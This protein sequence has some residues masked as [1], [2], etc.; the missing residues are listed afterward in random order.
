LV[1]A[2]DG[3]L[4]FGDTEFHIRLSDIITCPPGG[5]DKAGQNVGTRSVELRDVAVSTYIDTDIYQ[6]P[7]AGKVGA[8]GGRFPGIRPDDAAFRA[9]STNVSGSTIGHVNEPFV[10]NTHTNL[11][12]CAS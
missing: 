4:R 8:V 12:R 7:D 3:S 11:Y 5:P 1:V 10:R 2:Y 6:F 9:S